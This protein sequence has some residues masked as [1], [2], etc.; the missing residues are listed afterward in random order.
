MFTPRLT[1]NKRWEWIKLA[2]TGRLREF[3]PIN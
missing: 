2:A 1:I 3:S